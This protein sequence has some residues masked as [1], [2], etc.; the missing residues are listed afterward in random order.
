MSPIPGQFENSSL[1]VEPGQ[2]TAGDPNAQE[3]GWE[4]Y[5]AENEPTIIFHKKFSSPKEMHYHVIHAFSK[6]YTH[7]HLILY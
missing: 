1:R 2:S 5:F 4:S 7:M 6:Y 3:V